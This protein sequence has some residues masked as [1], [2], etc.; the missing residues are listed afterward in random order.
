MD[1]NQ[2][3]TDSFLAILNLL[4]QF[5]GNRGGIDNIIVVYG[6]GVIL[7][8][9][10]LTMSW[11]QTSTLL[12]PKESLLRTGYIL[13]MC[14]ELFMLLMALML[15]LKFFS[16]PSL[17][18]FFP[19]AEHLL[20]GV[21]LVVVEGSYIRY[22][23]PNYNIARRFLR[24]GISVTAICYLASFWWWAEYS[25]TNPSSLFSQTWCDWAFHLISSS[26]TLIAIIIIAMKSHGWLRNMLIT[27]L[28][29]FF[30]FQFGKIPD[31]VFHDKYE[32]ILAPIGRLAYLI[33]IPIL[34][35]LYLIEA[36]KNRTTQ[37]ALIWQQANYDSLTKLPNRRLFHDRLEHAAMRSRSTGMP[38]A[39]LLINLDQLKEVN[40]TLGH[41][42]GDLLLVETA[43][44]ISACVRDT[45]NI[46]RLGGDEFAII[47][48]EFGERI[49][50][51]RIA[52]DIIQSL[53]KPCHLGSG[54][55]AYI[56][57]SIGIALYPN[58]THDLEEL[59]KHADQAMYAAK[60]QGRNRFDYF[61][62]AMQVA[63]QEKR[64]LTSDLRHAL[65][66]KQLE[67]Y[68][69]P[70]ANMESG[71][72]TKAEALLRW[73]H[74]TRG[75]ISP[76]TF[77]PLAE[78]SGLIL[79]IG[80]WVF[81][82]AIANIERWYKQFG[83]I[84]QVSVNMSPLQ[85]EKAVSHVWMDTLAS[86]GLPINSINVEITEGLLIKDST[87][88]KL[89]LMEFR[90]RGIEVSIDDF[91]TGFSSL[92]YL[93]QLDIDYLKIDRSFIINLT[94]D[95]SD[96]A[97]VEAIVVM[98]HKLGMKT[99]AEGVETAAQRDQLAA[100]GCDY[101]QGYLY[102]RPVPAAEFEKLLTSTSQKYLGSA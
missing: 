35:L 57:A 61:T 48:T 82:Q 88:V 60:A 95:S 75:M 84:I 49:H 31:M 90:N 55:V 67:V 43:Q 13:V 8:G 32:Y 37:D 97:L 11:T 63:T 56:S 77:I 7:W 28:C 78:E 80:E 74:P 18:K 66:H 9:G 39:L 91:G 6:L 44:R 50:L 89:R 73:H 20:I 94:D 19:P 59:I 52:Q 54:H 102:S 42:K 58:N 14:R 33:A 1:N 26:L 27:A 93:K 96:K 99:I 76:M 71:V 38:L 40:D 22:L 21:G 46:A 65:E 51:E 3:L 45:D 69:Q 25:K 4:T 12:R 17:Y 64:E 36:Y 68:Y 24:F 79:D 53:S 101:A 72:I 2:S 16:Q 30:I 5:T 85:F 70:I 34:G 10:C 23:I 62:H 86:S 81:Q 100:Y 98:A 41:T 83:R 29:L 87:T 15:A 47:L 92:S